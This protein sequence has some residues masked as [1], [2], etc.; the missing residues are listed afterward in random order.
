MNDKFITADGPLVTIGIPTLNRPEMLA[1]AVRSALEQDYKNIEVV[2]CDNA[3]APPARAA[4]EPFLQDARLRYV[5]YDEHVGM[6][7]NWNRCFEMAKG[8]LWL[9]LSDDDWIEPSAVQKMVVRF[10][11][12]AV[13]MAVC[14]R[15]FETEKGPVLSEMPG[16]GTMPGHEYILDRLQ[17]RGGGCPAAEMFRTELVRQSGGYQEIGFAMDLLL[18]LDAGVEGDVAYIKEPLVHYALHMGNAS[19]TR[20]VEYIQSHVALSELARTRYEMRVAA[21]VRQYCIRAIYGRIKGSALDR[22]CV[23]VRAGLDAL[24]KLNAPLSIKTPA[25]ILNLPLIQLALNRL[26]VLKRRLKKNSFHE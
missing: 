17:G 4:L 5:Y 21:E 9:C 6:V 18:E 11:D 26:R 20:S 25:W 12:G 7:A 22:N 3:S 19:V 8:D 13:G 2:V 15:Y 1:K 14:S 10:K 24:L 16:D 23:V